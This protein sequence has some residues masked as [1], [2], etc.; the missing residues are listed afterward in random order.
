VI[1]YSYQLTAILEAF[2]INE[3]DSIRKG[4]QVAWVKDT[5]PTWLAIHCNTTAAPHIEQDK[6]SIAPAD[7]GMLPA[8]N[9]R[10]DNHIIVNAPPNGHQWLIQGNVPPSIDDEKS[11]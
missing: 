11:I 9:W 7:V 4:D 6:M 2:S 3:G 1:I 5:L 10:I 8:D